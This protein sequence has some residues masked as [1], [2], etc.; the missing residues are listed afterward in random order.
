[1]THSATVAAIR[2]S[3]DLAPFGIDADQFDVSYVKDKAQ[4]PLTRALTR[5]LYGQAADGTALVDGVEF[6]SRHGDELRLWAIFERPHNPV[7][8][9]LL[10]DTTDFEIGPD[11]E[12][13]SPRCGFTGSA[14]PTEARWPTVS[15]LTVTD[16]PL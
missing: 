5:W 10:E 11:H 16:H 9:P 3:F 6:R 4:R 12:I 2:A 7:V 14:G 8:T 1:V 13:S 15:E